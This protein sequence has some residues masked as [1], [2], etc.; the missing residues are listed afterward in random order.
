MAPNNL[1]GK[2]M[3]SGDGEVVEFKRSVLLEGPVEAWLKE[4]GNSF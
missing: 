1:E 4:I 3:I 2:A